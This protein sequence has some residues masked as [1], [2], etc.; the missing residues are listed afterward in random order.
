MVVSPSLHLN[1]QH[2]NEKETNFSQ[3]GPAL[4]FPRI[5]KVGDV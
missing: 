3:Q 4:F 1:T 5:A 2:E